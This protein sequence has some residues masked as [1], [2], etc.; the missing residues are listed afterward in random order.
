VMTERLARFDKGHYQG[1]GYLLHPN[2]LQPATLLSLLPGFGAEH[3]RLAERA[4]QIGGCIA[5][6]DD[7]G[8]GHVEVDEDGRPHWTYDLGEEDAAMLRDAMKV[9][10]RVLLAA[11][12]RECI[13]PDAAGTRIRDEKEVARIDTVDFAPGSMMF[14]AP[15]P[16]G[17]C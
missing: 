2:Q 1:G 7:M 10:A 6:V 15:H 13:V 4:H 3:R 14:V 12:A 16:A 11:G 9:Q 8:S 17:M 5:W